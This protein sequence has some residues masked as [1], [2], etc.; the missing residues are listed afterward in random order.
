MWGFVCLNNKMTQLTFI[1][2]TKRLMNEITGFCATVL[3]LNMGHHLLSVS[4][5]VVKGLGLLLVLGEV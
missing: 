2:W 4:I 3:F 1:T 5:T